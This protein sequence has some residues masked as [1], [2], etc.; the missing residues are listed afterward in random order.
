MKFKT[1]I[2]DD[3]ALFN[4]GLA[5]ILKECAA[6]EVVGQVYDSRKATHQ[7]QLLAPD[8]VLLDYNMPYLNGLH[9][10]ASLQTLLKKPKIVII[11]M[12]AD[13]RELNLFK[14]ANV[15]GFLTKTTSSKELVSSLTK[16]MAGVKLLN[17]GAP[18][19]EASVKDFFA[20]KHQ[21]T[22]REYEIVKLL[23]N[24]ETTDQIAVKL[25]L[26]YFTVETHRKNINAKLKLHNK[27]EFYNFVQSLEN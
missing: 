17:T 24:G 3:H 26:S 13:K 16:I 25:G 20:L 7:C 12:Y 21:L 9:V 19:K 11:S 1:L 14:A 6:F 5:L 10:V 8:L 22:K 23:K 15:D 18:A 2:I 27:Q 4:E